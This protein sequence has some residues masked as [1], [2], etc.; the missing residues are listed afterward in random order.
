[1]NTERPSVADLRLVRDGPPCWCP[2]AD[3]P[4]IDPVLKVL[5][6]Y[7]AEGGTKH[8]G[9]P[10]ARLAESGWD[11]LARHFDVLI[12]QAKAAPAVWGRELSIDFF[13]GDV[14]R[15]FGPIR[16]GSLSPILALRIRY[17]LDQRLR[18]L[19][20][21]V[22]EHLYEL[23]VPIVMEVAGLEASRGHTLFVATSIVLIGGV[24]RLVQ[25]ANKMQQEL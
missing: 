3:R 19:L 18:H 14:E 24:Q 7:S 21:V 10:H 12:R 9:E 13:F 4:I 20:W 22:T 16:R 15:L 23:G 8:E 6:Y 5:N 2:S 17:A 11:H 25:I 1:M